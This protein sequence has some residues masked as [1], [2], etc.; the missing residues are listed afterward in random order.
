MDSILAAAHTWFLESYQQEPYGTLSIRLVEGIK[1]DVKRPVSAGEV[2]L[3]S[4]YP[5]TVEPHSKCAV[6][7]FSD[8]RTLLT[9][10]EGFDAKDDRFTAQGSRYIQQVSDSALRELA[11]RT[12]NAIDDHRGVYSEWFIWTE[13]QIFHVIA[14]APPKIQLENREPNLVIKRHTWYAS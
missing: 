11:R 12:L 1:G 3:G 14:G 13:D 6:I 5:V 2:S 4:H 8:V 9:Y 7:E 10:P